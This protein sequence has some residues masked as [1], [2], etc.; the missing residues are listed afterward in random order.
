MKKKYSNPIIR[1][2]NVHS[3]NIIVTSEIGIGDDVNET[4]TQA[5]RHNGDWEEYNN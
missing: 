4:T 2:H 3:S 5:P 1:L